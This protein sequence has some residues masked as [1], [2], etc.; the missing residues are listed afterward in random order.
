M[1]LY[2]GAHQIASRFGERNLYQYLFVGE[3]VVLLDAGINS[4]PEKVI[5]PYL[6]RLG[7]SPRRL[8]MA[9]ISHPDLDHQG[10]NAALREAHGEI[11]LACHRADR[12]LIEDPAALYAR[13][14]NHLVAEHG[15][16]LGEAMRPL[17]G[18]KTEL[19][20]LFTGG[21]RL[22]LAPDWELEIWHVPGHSD[23]HLAIYDPRQQ[24]LF[25][26]DAAHGR[27]CPTAAGGM[28]FGPTYYA[29]N[30]YLSTLHFLEQMPVQHLY[31][32]HWPDAHG[33]AV[34]EFLAGSRQFVELA[35]R[36][37]EPALAAAGERGATL[38]ELITQLGPRLGKWPEEEHKLLM[39]ALYGHL[40]RL[41]QRGRARRSGGARPVRWR[42]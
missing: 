21:E 34:R 30:A 37:L 16:G 27:G 19:D 4:T 39:Y 23:G 26:S 25:C 18:R 41:E 42:V 20:A 12:E 2:P 7:L 40:E 31:S 9:I 3:R 36:L 14:Y 22:R 17:A 8:M 38:E 24:A 13:R 1:E 15:I 29:V 35:D 11:L 5:F 32:G 28:A 10:G 33:R 6:E